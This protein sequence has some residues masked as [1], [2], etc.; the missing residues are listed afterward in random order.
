MR[1]QGHTDIPLEP[2]GEDQARLL[3]ARLARRSVPFT[4]VW[5]SDL[6][7]AQQTAAILA[8]PHNLPIHATPLLRETGMGDWEGLTHADILARGEGEHF[9]RFRTDSVRYP[10]PN[11]ETLV[12]AQMRIRTALEQIR[13][14]HLSGQVIVVGHGGSLRLAVLDVLDAP[15]LT[16]HRFTLANTSLTIIEERTGPG[17]HSRRLELLND[18]SHLEP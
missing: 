15:L 11:S 7:R 18:V 9:M 8:A 1:F 13:V 17:F 6:M 2:E 12:D 10:P 3:A 4:A 16:R 14:S 5:S